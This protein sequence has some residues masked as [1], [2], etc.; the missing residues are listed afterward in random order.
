MLADNNF[1]IADRLFNSMET[2]WRLSSS[3]S[4]TDFKEL[5]PEFYCLPEFLLNK[6]HLNMGVRQNGDVVNDVILQKWYGSVM[7]CSV[8]SFLLFFHNG[9]PRVR[10]LRIV[11]NSWIIS[12]LCSLNMGFFCFWE[13]VVL[14][15][16]LRNLCA[17]L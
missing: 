3:E 12:N 7:M 14:F 11:E 10:K 4:T 5:I 17:H 9:G 8:V 2:T 6:E 1:D 16:Q 15:T 13:G